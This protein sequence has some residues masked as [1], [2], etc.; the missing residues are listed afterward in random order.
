MRARR[1]GS[2]IENKLMKLSEC[3][4]KKSCLND[5]AIVRNARKRGV[6]KV[7]ILHGHLHAKL[8]QFISLHDK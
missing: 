6:Y 7:I 8:A 5:R 1:V 2:E 4:M 3:E